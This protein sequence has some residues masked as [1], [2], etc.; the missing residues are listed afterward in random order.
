LPVVHSHIYFPLHSIRLREVAGFLGSSL[1]SGIPSGLE[2]VV[3]RERWRISGEEEL[4]NEL[5]AYNREDCEA[6]RAVCNFIRESVAL[7]TAKDCVPGRD[8]RIALTDYLRKTG[9]GNRP[10]FKKAEF[11]LPGFERVNRCAY[12]DY[13]RDKVYA[14]V[15]RR[16]VQQRQRLSY[17]V[18]S[19]S[20]DTEI[21]VKGKNCLQCGSNRLSLQRTVR[22]R[23]IDLKF[24]KTGI[25]VKRW[26]PHYTIHKY[27]CRRC[28]AIVTPS[29]VVFNT[30]SR[31]IYGHNLKCWCVYHNIVC[32]QSML[33]VERSLHD[34]FGLRLP[35]G[36]V[37]HFRSAIAAYYHPLCDEI[38]RAILDEDVINIDETPVNLRKTTGYVWVLATN[39]KVYYLYKESREGV[40]LKDLLAGFSGILVSDFF[41]AY[42]SLVC[43]HQKCLVHLMRDIND[44]LRRYPFDE[45]LRYIAQEFA[46]FLVK[47]VSTIDRWGL[48]THHLHKHLKDA[49]RLLWRICRR[50]LASEQAIK[51]Q[52]RCLRFFAMT[53]FRGTI[54]MPN[55]RFTTL[56]RC[57]VSPTGHLQVHP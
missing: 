15:K 10:V 30:E 56:R 53:T 5:I 55:M 19:A 24:F 3:F 26:Q 46:V 28:G 1:K 51:Y 31:T 49:D 36:K 38:L 11:V 47:V 50:T 32:K 45:E 21:V 27:R 14:R 16:V 37:Y 29:G 25:G 22:R 42:D 6:V 48:K 41:T 23:F 54:T 12:F 13:Q 39:D 57:A 43:H 33:Q 34:I 52:K 35:Y 40:F 4:K 18:R 8:E 2:S 44:D 7:A 9:D 17:A 20:Q